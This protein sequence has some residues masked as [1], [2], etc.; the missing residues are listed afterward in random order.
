MASLLA[1]IPLVRIVK[2]EGE[3]VGTC[4]YNALTAGERV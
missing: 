4:A 3:Q 2:I 1:I